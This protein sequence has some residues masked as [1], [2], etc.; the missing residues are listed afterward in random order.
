MNWVSYR[1]LCTDAADFANKLAED[2]LH[3][4]LVAV[5][6]APR[7]GCMPASMLALHRHWYYAG[8]EF[9]AQTGKFYE[10]GDRLKSFCDMPK[11]GKVLLLDDSA[12]RC[13][14]INAA[15]RKI[16]DGGK[17]GDFQIVRG[18]MYASQHAVK[19]EMLDVYFRQLNMPRVF[20]WNLF[21]HLSVRKWA[22]S[23]DVLRTGD[24]VPSRKVAAIVCDVPETLR[25]RMAGILEK[26]GVQYGDL[27]M[28]PAEAGG[29]EMDERAKWKGEWYRKS[30]CELFVEMDLATAMT[31]AEV[32]RKPVVCLENKRLY[33]VR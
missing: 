1:Q 19:G 25:K 7:S 26:V 12:G 16:A 14:S 17:C 23:F 13:N 31:V 24:R 27:A 9:F 18:A 2:P 5:I 30:K 15:C 11:Q 33:Q 10:P 3:K 28:P 32:S 29:W 20:E 22:F 6:G 21:G 4:D 8:V